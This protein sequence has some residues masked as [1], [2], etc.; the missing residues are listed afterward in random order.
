M[1]AGEE[2]FQENSHL[3]LRDI[4][5]THLSWEHGAAVDIVRWSMNVRGRPTHHR[6]A[7]LE[8]ESPALLAYLE[9][10]AASGDMTGWR[11]VEARVQLRAEILR[12]RELQPCA[13][14]WLAAIWQTL[15]EFV[16]LGQSILDRPTKKSGP[17]PDAAPEAS[18]TA[19]GS[20][21]DGDNGSSGKAGSATSNKPRS[22]SRLA[23]PIVT[24]TLTTAEEKALDLGKDSED[25]KTKNDITPDGPGGAD[26]PV[27]PKPPGGI[28]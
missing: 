20:G 19:T 2:I 22:P 28:K 13:R 23:L 27:G 17:V 6:Q 21:G 9:K 14:P 4:G 24:V 26:G 5:M 10:L 3:V 18:D 15:P 12:E 25:S 8:A 7:F 1:T 11:T 16:A